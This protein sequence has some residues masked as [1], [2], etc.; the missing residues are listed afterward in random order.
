LEFY[1]PELVLD[2]LLKFTIVDER[3]LNPW[4]EIVDNT[5]EKREQ[6]RNSSE[7]QPD[8]FG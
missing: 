2:G 3:N 5:F 1:L 6:K 4:E 7:S 8:L